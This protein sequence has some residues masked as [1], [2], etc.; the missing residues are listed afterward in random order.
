[1]GEIMHNQDTTT[2]HAYTDA[3]ICAAGREIMR[4]NPGDGY[5]LFVAA[6]LSGG[7]WYSQG[8]APEYNRDTV[9]RVP[10][11]EIRAVHHPRSARAYGQYVVR[12]IAANADDAAESKRVIK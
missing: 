3:Q 11:P 8:S 10:V 9:V 4:H 2:E 12:Y 5:C 1:M 7:A 6:D